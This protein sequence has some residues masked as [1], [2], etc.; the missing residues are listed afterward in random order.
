MQIVA[1]TPDEIENSWV[2]DFRLQDGIADLDTPALF[3]AVIRHEGPTARRAVEVKLTINGSEADS[4]VIDLEPGQAR[5]VTFSYRFDVPVE[6]GHANFVQAVVSIPHDRQR[7]GRRTLS[8]GAGDG[9]GAEFR[10]HRPAGPDGSPAKNRYRR[11]ALA[12]AVA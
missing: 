12:A 5:E 7:A 10:V 8:D 6:E 3:T 4:K 2:A 9:G 1:V 11:N